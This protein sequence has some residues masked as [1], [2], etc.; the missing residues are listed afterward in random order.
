M[1]RCVNFQNTNMTVSTAAGQRILLNSAVC[2]DLLEPAWG[3]F[4]L[5]PDTNPPPPL[6]FW[7]LGD[8]WG[9]GPLGGGGGVPGYPN[10]RTSK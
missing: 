10:I 4:R 3:A 8:G 9:G 5:R 1:H 7:T 2:Q 6:T